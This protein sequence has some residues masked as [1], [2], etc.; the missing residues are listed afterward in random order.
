[1][2]S[3]RQ[4]DTAA[5]RSD[6][7]V[8]WQLSQGVGVISF[9]PAA[10]VIRLKCTTNNCHHLREQTSFSPCV[11]HQIPRGELVTPVA[12]GHLGRARP[13]GASLNGNRRV[14]S[15]PRTAAAAAAHPSSGKENGDTVKLA[16]F[17][18]LWL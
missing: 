1:M 16:P 3:R 9:T 10:A 7:N 18:L 4:S 12:G 13:H 14:T 11:P 8:L 15:L 2:L 5:W 17:H 6:P